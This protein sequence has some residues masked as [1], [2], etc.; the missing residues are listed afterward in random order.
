MGFQS[1][2]AKA[3]KYSTSLDVGNYILFGYLKIF[4]PEDSIIPAFSYSFVDWHVPYDYQRV[5]SG[6]V[7]AYNKNIVL[8][9]DLSNSL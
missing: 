3:W 5:R 8:L 2:Q 6:R 1:S 4:L 7:P 9:S